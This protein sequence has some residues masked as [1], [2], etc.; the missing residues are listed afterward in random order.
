MKPISLGKTRDN[1][2]SGQPGSEAGP[3]S[4]DIEIDERAGSVR[5]YDPRVFHA[6]RRPFCRRLTEATVRRPGVRRVEID[7]A[8]A[9]CRI[10]FGPGPGMSQA[11]AVAFADSVREAASAPPR[12]DRASWWRPS[13]GWS[14]LT[15]Y[16]LAGDVSL[17]E[18]Q[19]V[20][21]GRIRLRHQMQADDAVPLSRLAEKMA[22]REDVQ[23]C[24]VSFWSRTIVLD[25]RPEIAV[26]DRFPDEV[27]QV[28]EDM[29]TAGTSRC[30][31]SAPAG[32]SVNGEV[33][34]VATGLERFRYLALAGGSFAMTVGAP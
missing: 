16:T 10:D 6:G 3:F 4:L 5:V 33:V 26:A 18:T 25:F 13:P 21:P 24:R 28:L 12:A 15:A 30:G 20:K 31:S 2:P 27:E 9:S 29:L 34:E 14:I 23:G 32:P 7:L 8:S 17:W 1:A 22:G 19:E 11:M